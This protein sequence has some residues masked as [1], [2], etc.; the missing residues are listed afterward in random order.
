MDEVME[1]IKKVNSRSVLPDGWLR[2]NH[3]NYKLVCSVDVVIC[4]FLSENLYSHLIERCYKYIEQAKIN[5]ED[6]EY[7]ETVKLLLDKIKPYAKEFYCE[8]SK[9]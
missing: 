7:I 9:S 4:Q 3:G 2:R 6:I 1:L 5:N 8:E